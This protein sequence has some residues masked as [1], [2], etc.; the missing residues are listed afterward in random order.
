MARVNS[1][2]VRQ[3]DKPVGCRIGINYEQ[4]ACICV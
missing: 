2:Q 3:D 1:E 4:D